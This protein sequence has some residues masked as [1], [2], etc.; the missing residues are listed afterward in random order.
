M[1]ND[2]FACR[3]LR[4]SER[5]RLL[6]AT[7]DGVFLWPGTSLVYRQGNG[8]FAAEPRVVNSAMGLLFGPAA[9]D[10]RLHSILERARDGLRNGRTAAVQDELDRLRLPRVSLNGA[11]L[12][13]AIAEHQELSLPHVSI[14]TREGGTIWSAED[15]GL[16]ARLYDGFL[17]TAQRLEKIFNPGLAWD[18]AKHPRQ[19]AGQSDGG[20]FA[21]A[22]G[23]DSS[24]I[25]VAGP[26]PPWRE[27][28]EPPGEPPKIPNK[29]PES[30][31]AKYLAIRTVLYW[32]G[33]AAEAGSKAAPP[34]IKAVIAAAQSA[35]WL[36]PYVSASLD[37]PKTLDE[38][39]AG[40]DSPSTGYHIHHI[41]EQTSAEKAGFPRNKIDDRSN[42]AKIPEVKHWE[43]NWWFG[44]SNPE[45]DGKSPREYVQGKT[46]DERR[47]V[48]LDGLKAVGALKE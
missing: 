1:L 2:P 4:A 35:A 20:E 42:L 22:G 21:P 43:L 48:G 12:M 30:Q 17:E 45:Y 7:G 16:F 6:V 19:P 10:L 23:S 34:V 11:R 13:V 27:P 37:E 25:P 32:L 9:L 46:W 31:A 38:L 33:K 8:F 44:R 28:K 39:Q 3:G 41:V 24:I 5:S 47:K 36:W 26:K 15:V 18:S 14:A 40:V 29:E